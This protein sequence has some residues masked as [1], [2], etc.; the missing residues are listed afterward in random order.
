ADYFVI[1][2]VLPDGKQVLAVLPATLPGVTVG[3]P[4]DLMALEGSL[5]AEVRCDQVALDRKWLLAGPAERVLAG[6]RGGTGGL[7]TSCLALGL[8]GAAVGYML[9]E[10]A[11]RPELGPAAGRLE[12]ARKKVR[13]DLHRLAREGPT[14]EAAA[15]LRTRAN[16]LVLRAT[17]AAL[18]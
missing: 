11:S 14:P 6:G 17:Q 7:E 10:A 3:P 18:T 12:E 1:G 8:A 15:A 9:Q 2:A 16:A 13:T 5:T 4:L